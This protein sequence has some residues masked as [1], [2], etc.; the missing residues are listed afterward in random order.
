[1]RIFLRLGETT[2]MHLPV[3]KFF[4]PIELISVVLVED[5]PLTTLNLRQLFANLGRMLYA[6]MKIFDRCKRVAKLRKR[7]THNSK[8]ND[9][10][11]HQC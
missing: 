2:P 5:F 10:L 1:M 9:V 4:Y 6:F 3:R 11:N 7:A 8:T